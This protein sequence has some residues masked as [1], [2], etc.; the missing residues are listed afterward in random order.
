[1]IVVHPFLCV[2]K[3]VFSF[4]QVGLSWLN[5]SLNP[6]AKQLA[7]WRTPTELSV[8]EPRGG[9]VLLG[10]IPKVPT[11]RWKR[12]G[13]DAQRYFRDAESMST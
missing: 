2:L 1:M 8:A 12:A 11:L 7:R 4:L 10:P 13:T 3:F 9:T 5:V 6:A